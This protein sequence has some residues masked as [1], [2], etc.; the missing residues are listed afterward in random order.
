[1]RTT[2]D[3]INRLSSSD[4]SHRVAALDCLFVL[5]RRLVAGYANEVMAHKRRT[6]QAVEIATDDAVHLTYLAMRRRIESNSLLLV[7]GIAGWCRYAKRTVAST[8]NDAGRRR[9]HWDDLDS[10]GVVE[11]SLADRRASSRSKKFF[12]RMAASKD[13]SAPFDSVPAACLDPK[14]YLIRAE[15]FDHDMAIFSAACRRLT[16][17]ERELLQKV[18][19]AYEGSS[20]TIAQVGRAIHVPAREIHALFDSIRRAA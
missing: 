10:G 4:P 7:R 5:R 15:T 14:N 8:I 18:L 3:L 13:A 12:V 11:Q 6:D 17:E 1:M 2:T 16:G 19:R 9:A 20:V